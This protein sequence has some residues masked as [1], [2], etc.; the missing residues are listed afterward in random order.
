[1]FFN[2][3]L[4]NWNYPAT[5]PAPMPNRLGMLTHPAWLVAHAHNTATD[6]IQRGKWVR[7]KLLAGTVPKVPITVDAVIPEDHQQTL[8]SRLAR[9]TEKE[10]CWKCHEKMN[11]IGYSFEVF[12]D[13]GRFR[14]AEE[15]EHPDNRLATGPDKGPPE[16]N[17]RDTFKTLPVDARGFLAGTGDPKLDGEV[18]DAF[19]LIRRLAKSDRVRQSVLRH[20]FRFFLG[21]NE[22]LADSKTLID[23]DHAYLSSGGSFDAVILSL[24]T[25]DSFLYRKP[26]PE[27]AHVH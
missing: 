22:T 16:D 1:M 20:A 8:R 26:S 14:T 23:A 2:I 5:Q 17:W 9:A 10:Y 13:F 6:P 27:T 18:T 3:A 4:D 11:P 7:E 15:L 24:L 21:R 19:D 12:D 25:S